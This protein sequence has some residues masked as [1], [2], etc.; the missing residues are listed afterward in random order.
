MTSHRDYIADQDIGQL[1]NLINLATKRKDDLQLGGWVALWVVGDYANQGWFGIDNYSGAVAFLVKLA[2]KHIDKGE[3]YELEISKQ[4]YRPAEAQR[5]LI[6]T[7]RRLTASDLGQSWSS[8][9]ADAHDRA[10]SVATNFPAGHLQAMGTLVRSLVATA[11]PWTIAKTALQQLCDAP[12]PTLPVV[13]P[14]H[15]CQPQS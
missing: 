8:I 4:L 5:L 14:P 10:F 3:C 15:S 6:D 11:T 7:N 12:V 1:E 2:Q 13:E 9:L